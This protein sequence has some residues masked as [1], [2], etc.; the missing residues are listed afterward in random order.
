[1]KTVLDLHDLIAVFAPIDGVSIND[2]DDKS[3]WRI[4][5]KEEATSDQIVAANSILQS[6]DPNFYS[7]DELKVI[8]LKQAA[9]YTSRF[10]NQ[11]QINA[12]ILELVGGNTKAQ[13]VVLWTRSIKTEA[14]TN[15]RNP[16]FEKFTPPPYTF[17]EVMGVIL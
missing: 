17:E 13:A 12:M 4:D 14:L 10:F 16:N 11:E 5:F 1:M 2:L 6:F 3:T 8:A 9:E 7:D 15:F